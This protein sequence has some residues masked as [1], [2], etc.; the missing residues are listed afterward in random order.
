MDV[1]LLICYLLFRLIL[2]TGSSNSLNRSDPEERFLYELNIASHIIWVNIHVCSRN[3]TRWIMHQNV[4]FKIRGIQSP[5]MSNT[6]SNMLLLEA[7]TG[8]LQWK[9]RY[10]AF[11]CMNKGPEKRWNSGLSLTV[12][13][14]FAFLTGLALKSKNWGAL[15]PSCGDWQLCKMATVSWIEFMAKTGSKWKDFS[16]VKNRLSNSSA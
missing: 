2:C 4:I 15:K 8:Y 3:G 13:G 14:L 10:K 12:V 1:R 6:N 7:K 5:G 11:W 9:F 16:K